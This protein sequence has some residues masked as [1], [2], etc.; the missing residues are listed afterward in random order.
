MIEVCLNY[1]HLR[2]IFLLA[3]T[4]VNDSARHGQ[5]HIICTAINNKYFLPASNNIADF[6]LS[7]Y[8]L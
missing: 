4:S 2:I 3:H 1:V 7:K 8:E 6:F 5:I